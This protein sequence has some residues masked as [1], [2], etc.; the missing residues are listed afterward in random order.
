MLSCSGDSGD[1]STDVTDPVKI[2]P[3]NLTLSIEIVG[4]SSQNPNGD[5]SGL[6]RFSA[7]ANDA[8]N[9]SFRF[10]TGDSEESATGVVEYTYSDVGTNPYNVNVLAYSSTNDFASTS[11]TI[12][13]FVLPAL[14]PDITQ[15]LTGGTEKSWKVNAAYDAHFSNGDKQ[16]KYPTWWEASSFSKSNSGFYDDKFIFKANGTYIHETNGD[17]YGKANYLNQTFGNTGQPINSSNEIEKYSLSNYQTTFSIVKENNENKLSFQDKGFIGFFVGQHQFTIEC[18]DDNNLF[19]RAVDDQNRA[20]YI[21]LT[22][23]EVSTTPSKDLYTNLIWQEE[24]DYNGKIDDNK[25][26]Y[27]VRD[28]W[29]NEELQATTDRLENVIVQDGKLKIIAKRESYNGKSFTSGRIKS[30]GKFD[31]TYGRVDIR[32]KLPGKKGTWPALWLL[33]SNYDDIDW[34]KC[35]E[36]D[37]MEHAGN[38]LNK[39]QGTVHHPDK[40]G[41]GDGG[42]TNDYTNVSTAFNTYS[43]V[44]NEKAITFLVNDKPFHIV[45]NAC[46]LPFNWDFF[47][48]LNIAMGGTFG[49][50]VPD[51]F[52]SDIMEV[53]YVR[54]YQ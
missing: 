53:D 51:S 38:R 49:G 25:W 26:V 8:V 43:V 7:T 17:V 16:F 12:S 1:D 34:P 13:V 20:W 3:T 2:I 50:S 11:Q 42:E 6:V 31:F 14:D 18:Y 28:Q 52:V 30:N 35:G 29:Y 36:I 41:S 44:W 48:I 39:I 32:A 10:G 4:S 40:H 24:F 37:I 21:W 15:V 22:D 45:G 5:G 33:G 47:L 46:A 23:Q 27:E 9:F 19:V 54:V